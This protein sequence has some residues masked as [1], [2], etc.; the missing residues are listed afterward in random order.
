M[1]KPT[2]LSPFLLIASLSIGCGGLATNVGGSGGQVDDHGVGAG[3]GGGDSSGGGALS[4]LRTVQEI[5]ANAD[6]EPN[7]DTADPG[8]EAVP[9]GSTACGDGSSR[10][11]ICDHAHQ[12][13]EAERGA[14]N[15]VE[16]CGNQGDVLGWLEP[17]PVCRG[18]ACGA[19][20]EHDDAPGEVGMCDR[21]SQCVVAE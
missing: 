21:R 17:Q 6:T 13:V 5:C 15:P 1:K 7:S 19:P 16:L 20:C 8:C 10:L 2:Q 9:C 3:G 11:W 14:S 18:M 12:C 4:A